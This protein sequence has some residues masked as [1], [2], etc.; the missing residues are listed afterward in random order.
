MARTKTNRNWLQ[1]HRSDPYVK[2]AQREGFYSRA[3]YKLA[4]IDR[5]S[6]LLQRGMVVVDLGA[7]PGGWSQYAAQRVGVAGR[8]VAVDRLAMD[9]IEGVISLR[10][11]LFDSQSIADI[12]E[13][14]SGR[15]CKLVISDMAP[16]LSGHS[17][18]DLPRALALAERAAEIAEQLLTEGGS[19]LIK[20]FQGSG[21]DVFK[22]QLQLHYSVVKFLKPPASRDRSR[23][24]Y[25]LAQGYKLV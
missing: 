6:S 16:S 20:L 22:R 13:C 12:E 2:R 17:S 15:S 5:R 3:A 9:A 21:V 25:L 10:A 24:I 1:A 8:V 18:I 23:E 4:E 19:L 7:A 14:L 11:D